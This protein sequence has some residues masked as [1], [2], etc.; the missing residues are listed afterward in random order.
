MATLLLALF[1]CLSI[2]VLL[3]LFVWKRTAWDKID[4]SNDKYLDEDGDHAYYNRSLIEQ[5]ERQKR[6]EKNKENSE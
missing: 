1:L 6:F 5:K 4:K 3:F 2:L